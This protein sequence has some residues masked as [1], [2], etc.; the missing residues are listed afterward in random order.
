[1]LIENRIGH[2]PDM[3]PLNHPKNQYLRIHYHADLC[4]RSL[5]LLGR[6]VFISM[7]P[8]WTEQEIDGRI[9]VCR[10]AVI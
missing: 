8:D 7:N 1:M 10:E 4:P 2:H 6:T 3:N 9:A 5:D